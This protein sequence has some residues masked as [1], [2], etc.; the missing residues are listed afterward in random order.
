MSDDTMLALVFDRPASDVT[1]TDVRRIPRPAPGP[2][3]VAIAVEYAGINFKDVMMR[4]GDDGW[5]ARGAFVPGLEVA[6]TVSAV[7][8]GVDRWRVGDRVV[9]LTNT[10]GLAEVAI[11]RADLTVA[12]PNDLP[13]RIAAT[14]PGAITTAVLLVDRIG[15]VRDGDVVLVHSAAGGV[16]TAV[17]A[18]ARA[19]TGVTLVGTV[20]AMSRARAAMQAGYDIVLGRGPALADDIRRE[21]GGRGV[22]VVLDP[23]GTD[24]LDADL[25]VVAP[26]GRIVLFGNAGARP[27]AA[28]PATAQLFAHNVS[29]GGFSLAAL[30]RAQPAIVASAM[31]DALRHLAA[32]TVDLPITDVDGLGGAAAAQEALATGTGATKYVVRLGPSPAPRL[33]A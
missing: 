26:T 3:E 16:G 22:D 33:P 15:R 29:I 27:F 30:S 18:L 1:G 23:Q 8:T 7:G 24:L 17:A 13:T 14:A 11:A 21:L 19:R 2:G 6:G 9:A 28:L 10:G 5:V 20:G 4:R 12:I 32:G 31:E 25:A